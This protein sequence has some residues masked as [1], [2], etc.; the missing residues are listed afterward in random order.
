V[1]PSHYT[2]IDAE[3]A[4]AEIEALTSEHA[5][6][7]LHDGRLVAVP[8]A[9]ITPQPDQSFRVEFSLSRFLQ[10]GVMIIPVVAETLDVDKRVVEHVVRV[11]KSVQSKDV[12]VDEDLLRED[13]DVERVPVNRY[14]DVLPSVREEN[15]MTII[16]LVEEVLVVEKRL[17]L[18][19]EIRVTRRQSAEKFH[20]VYTLQSEEVH[21][22]RDGDINPL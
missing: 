9:A 2:L 21:V 13:V 22:E 1:T 14:I 15:G 7:K 4:S 16:P 18:R 20:E 10:D 11:S 3:G 6:V 8:R 19:E 5:T 17:L 12:T